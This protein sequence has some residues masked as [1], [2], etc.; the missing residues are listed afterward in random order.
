MILSPSFELLLLLAT[1]F[2]SPQTGF[3]HLAEEKGVIASN[4]HVFNFSDFNLLILKIRVKQFS[5]FLLWSCSH[6]G[7]TP[8]CAEEEAWVVQTWPVCPPVGQWSGMGT[9]VPPP[10][11]E[12]RRGGAVLPRNMVVQDGLAD[13][14]NQCL[15]FSSQACC[16]NSFDRPFFVLFC[17]IDHIKCLR[18]KRKRK[19]LSLTSSVTHQKNACFQA[20]CGQLSVVCLLNCCSQAAFK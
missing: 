10:P 2:F 18:E 19:K 4:L 16:E 8:L 12:W 5:L 6:S 7:P 17:A 1:N 3:V 15:L 9:V 20:S 11:Y 14:K 13:I